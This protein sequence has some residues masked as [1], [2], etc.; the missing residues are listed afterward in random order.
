MT[1]PL[2]ADS[3]VIRPLPDFLPARVRHAC[4]G[5]RI[6]FQIPASVRERMQVP[7]DIDAADWADKYR[8]VTAIDAHPGRWRNELVPH[9]VKAM[10]LASTPHVRQL[11]LCWPERAAKTNV[12]LN[13]VMRQ[14]DRGIDSGNV[15]WLMPNEHEAKKAIG[16]RVIEALKA[17]P[18]TARL[19]SRYADDTTRTIIR[20]RHGPRLFAAWAGSAAS[21]SSFFGKLCV[22]DECDK[23]EL[24]GVGKETDILTLFF[25]RGRDRDDSKFIIVSTPAQ[26]YVWKGTMG[27][28]QV[29]QYQS[30]CPHCEQYVSPGSDQVIIPDG[31]TAEDIAHGQ[32]PVHIV[33]PSCKVPWTDQARAAAYADGEWIIIKGIGIDNPATVGMHI[34]A[35]VLPNIPL[36]EIAEKIIL[37]RDGGSTEKKALA[38]GYDCKD[39]VPEQA[40]ALKDDHLLKFRSELARN[41]VPPDTAQV[42]ITVDTQQASFYYQ[43][44]AMGYAPAV[45]LHMM[46]HG[47]VDSFEDVEGLLERSFLDHEGRKFKITAGIIDSGGTRR[48]WQKHSRTHEVYEWCAAHRIMTPHKGIPGRAGEMISYKQVSTFPGSNKPIPGGLK[49]ANIRVD[50]FKDDLEGRLAKEPDDPKALSFHSKIDEGFAKHFTSETKDESGDWTHDRKKGRNDHFDCTVMALALR[51]MRKLRIPKKPGAQVQAQAQSQPAAHRSGGFVS[52]WKR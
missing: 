36:R 40:G 35:Y 39:Y 34:T 46:R 2:L 5:R 7:E 18:R 26:G 29:F 51:E 12:V 30:H 21:V 24:S 42:G 13:A 50:I 43:V 16:E 45:E 37:A 19:L 15:F 10:R 17:T 33:C 14:L 32:V 8:R 4:A 3:L 6:S 52:G 25:K 48:G 22:F 1:Q 31:A 49:R 20:F 9:A 38:N 28:E 27:C 23:A 47:I 44:W 11:W 41:L